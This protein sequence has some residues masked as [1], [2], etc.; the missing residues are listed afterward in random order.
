MINASLLGV[1]FDN[2]AASTRVAMRGRMQA[3]TGGG[4]FTLRLGYNE[5]PL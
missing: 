2:I 5:T 4:V 3:P 1:L